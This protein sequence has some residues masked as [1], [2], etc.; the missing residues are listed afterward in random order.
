MSWL[1]VGVALPQAIC[2]SGTDLDFTIGRD[3]V[4]PGSIGAGIPMGQ[5]P[6]QLWQLGQCL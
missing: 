2:H 6:L 1:E 3:A 4:T 5:I